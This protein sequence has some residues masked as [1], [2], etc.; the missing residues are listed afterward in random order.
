MAFWLYFVTYP[1]LCISFSLIEAVLDKTRLFSFSSSGIFSFLSDNGVEGHVRRQWRNIYVSGKHQRESKRDKGQEIRVVRGAEAD[2]EGHGIKTDS[3]QVAWEHSR[4]TGW[5]RESTSGALR[6]PHW[7]PDL[8]PEKGLSGEAKKRTFLTNS[9]LAPTC[10]S[11]LLSD[12]CPFLF[13]RK[14]KGPQ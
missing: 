10:P 1:P 6:A 5:A 12:L 8:E 4:E 2:R 9:R 13:C 7:S 14:Y 3:T 11:L